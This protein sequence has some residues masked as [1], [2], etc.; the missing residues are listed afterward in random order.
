M[1]FCEIAT[2]QCLLFT[3]GLATRKVTV[4]SLPEDIWVWGGSF[5]S[6]PIAEGWHVTS[7]IIT[8]MI[9]L[10]RRNKVLLTITWFVIESWR[11][12]CVSLNARCNR[13]I[14]TSLTES[15]GKFSFHVSPCR[16]SLRWKSAIP[17]TMPFIHPT[18][19]VWQLNWQGA[20]S[21]W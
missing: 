3:Q 21:H 5:L 13:A 18:S 10:S 7:T 2:A 19:Y 12:C 15:S 8:R 4:T 1:G 6:L 14:K 9:L 20:V 17:T 11:I 16:S